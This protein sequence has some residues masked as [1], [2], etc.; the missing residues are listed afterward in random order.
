MRVGINMSEKRPG[1]H[2]VNRVVVV[3]AVA[4]AA[5]ATFLSAER[6]EMREYMVDGS[7]NVIV[8]FFLPRLISAAHTTPIG[9][10]FSKSDV[11]HYSKRLFLT[12]HV[13]VAVEVDASRERDHITDSIMKGILE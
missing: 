3:G 4:R 11:I 12:G 6:D 8:G 7:K 2:L 5:P 13:A 1:A 9:A 10:R